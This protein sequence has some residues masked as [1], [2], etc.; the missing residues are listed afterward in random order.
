LVL[1]SVLVGFGFFSLFNSFTNR[2]QLVL[3]NHQ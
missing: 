1:A 2:K 3:P